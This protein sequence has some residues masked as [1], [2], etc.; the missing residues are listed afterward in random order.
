MNS[1]AG[2]VAFPEEL[3]QFCCPCDV[4]DK[5]DDLIELKSIQQVVEL[6]ILFPFG[7]LAVV[8]LETVESKLGLIVN[9][10]FQWALH[11]L[12]ADWSSF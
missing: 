6:P 5:D 4:L 3:V 10:D 11:E 7:E 8:L 1:Y 12:L 9:V 2:E